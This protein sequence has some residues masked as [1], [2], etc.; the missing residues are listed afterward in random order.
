MIPSTTVR[1]AAFSPS[2]SSLLDQE[3]SSGIAT[4]REF[5]TA[6]QLAGLRSYLELVDSSEP[7]KQV[8]DE[9]WRRRGAALTQLKRFQP[10]ALILQRVHNLLIR[11]SATP[12]HLADRSSFIGS[13]D[14]GAKT[15]RAGTLS[16]AC[17]GLM[18]DERYLWKAPYILVASS[19]GVET[20]P[21]AHFD[22]LETGLSFVEG[23]RL[24]RFQKQT[25]GPMLEEIDETIPGTWSVI[26]V[27][28]YHRVDSSRTREGTSSIG[29][30]VAFPSSGL[31]RSDDPARLKS[32]Q[33]VSYESFSTAA[34][35]IRWNYLHQHNEGAFTANHVSLGQGE[36]LQIDSFDQRLDRSVVAV[37]ST[38]GSIEVAADGNTTRVDE[39]GLVLLDG[40]SA[41][42]KAD[43]VNTP[44][45]DAIQLAVIT[46]LDENQGWDDL[47]REG[48]L[49][50]LRV[51][52]A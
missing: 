44:V 40:V 2:S 13:L 27:G 1:D 34:G 7:A 41:T 11:N 15:Y 37:V 28:E 18:R 29:L 32:D 47:I 19:P 4:L 50:N 35:P 16:R 23:I 8:H 17:I 42:I 30:T 6:Y 10:A 43:T 49:N 51:L 26:S 5:A 20:E 22:T 33:R 31:D 38:G 12:E 24:H 46:L 52:G 9:L 3:L 21:H 48:Y 45:H 36:A 14:E 25:E 39:D